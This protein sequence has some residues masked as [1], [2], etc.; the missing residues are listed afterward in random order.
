MYYGSQAGIWWELIQQ[1]GV[2]LFLGIIFFLL[3][4]IC[5]IVSL[6]LRFVYKRKDNKG[7][8]MYLGFGVLLAGIWQVAQSAFRQ[9]MWPS[10]SP[11]ANMTYFA[12]MLM[13]LPFLIYVDQVQ[14]HRYH[15]IYRVLAVV[16][17]ADTVFCSVLQLT[18]VM[19]FIYTIYAMFGVLGAMLS[20]VCDRGDRIS[21][22]S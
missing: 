11:I 5:I 4:L 17:V 10:I 6:V 16:A 18:H 7:D 20:F 12:L 22:K 15:K 1:G 19:D 21:E 8:L 9:V 14:L 13:P 2:E 3:S